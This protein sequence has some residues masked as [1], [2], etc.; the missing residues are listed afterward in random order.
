M[1]V[2]Y[3]DDAKAYLDVIH[4]MDDAKLQLLLDA[5]EDEASKFMNVSDLTEWTE[6][7]MSIVIGVLLLLQGNYQASPDE[8]EKLRMAA[9]TKLLPYRVEMGV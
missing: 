1:S 3:L 8:V 6:L 7:P 2:I 9:E 5:A 4:G